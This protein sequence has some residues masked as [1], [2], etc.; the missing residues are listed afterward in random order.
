ME[1]TEHSRKILQS[2]IDVFILSNPNSIS[3][4]DKISYPHYQVSRS[5]SIMKNKER[6][7]DML[8]PIHAC[9]YLSFIKRQTQPSNAR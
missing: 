5:H 9:I 7:F 4:Q 8:R 6:L 1:T 2:Q 3:A